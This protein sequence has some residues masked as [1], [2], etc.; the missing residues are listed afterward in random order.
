[1]VGRSDKDRGLRMV[2]G[3]AFSV[4][5]KL[6]V[7]FRRECFQFGLRRRKYAGRFSVLAVQIFA[8]GL[9]DLVLDLRGSCPL[10]RGGGTVREGSKYT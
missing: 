6:G 10:G 5:E 9:I 1:M 3:S 8:T 4:L 2:V 7:R